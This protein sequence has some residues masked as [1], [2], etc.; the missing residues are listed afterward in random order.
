MQGLFVLSII[1][2][3]LCLFMAFKTF[4]PKAIKNVLDTSQDEDHVDAISVDEAYGATN[5]MKH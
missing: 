5:K 4:A 1:V 2:K 3:I